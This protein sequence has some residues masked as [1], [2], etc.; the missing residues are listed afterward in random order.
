MNDKITIITYGN[1][2]PNE[3][4]EHRT[5]I[6][7]SDGQEKEFYTDGYIGVKFEEIQEILDFLGIE[8]FEVHKNSY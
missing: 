4:E 1:H 6:K 2:R 7:R 8:Y 5:F 3:N